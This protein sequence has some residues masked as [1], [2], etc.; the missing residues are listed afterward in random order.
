MAVDPISTAGTTDGTGEGGTTDVVAGTPPD[1][2]AGGTEGTLTPQEAA[3]I[4]EENARLKAAQDQLLGEKN[5]F[6]ETSRENETLRR[7]LAGGG[8]VPPTS[9]QDP[10]VLMAQQIARDYAISQD[11]DSPLEDRVAATARVQAAGIRYTQHM[12]QENAFARELLSIPEP[13]RSE[14]EMRARRDGVMPGWALKDLESELWRKSQSESEAERKR[15]EAEEALRKTT[16]GKP[17]TT[18]TPVAGGAIAEAGYTEDEYA[19]LSRRAG[20]PEWNQEARKRLDKID[21]GLIKPR[22][23]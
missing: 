10:R 8:V 3:A 21:L 18:I 16:G 15:R 14:V 4:R 6:E 22:A 20:P 11:P 9:A 1:A 17:Q 13:H 12:E 23:G 5:K 2:T 7:Q 19:E